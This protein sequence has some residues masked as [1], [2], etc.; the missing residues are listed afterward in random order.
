MDLMRRVGLAVVAL[1]LAACTGPLD[2]QDH[3]EPGPGAGLS[4]DEAITEVL[5]GLGT[6][7]VVTIEP[8]ATPA[9]GN[10]N[11]PG[12]EVHVTGDPDDPAM[13]VRVSWLSSLCAGAV[14]AL[15]QTDEGVMSEVVDQVREYVDLP[16]GRSRFLGGGTGTGTWMG[17][18]P[19][20]DAASVGAQVRTAAGRFGL[21]VTE[22]EVLHPIGA[23]VM[24]TVRVPD[25]AAVDWTIDELRAAIEG[26]PRAYEGTLIE[27]DSAAGVPLLVSG[28]AWRVGAG[29][30]WFAEGQ[31]EVFGATH[32]Y[33]AVP[34]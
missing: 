28:A 27:I 2:R 6:E 3:A 34:N 29:S 7:A 1:V 20:R 33:L 15:M 18:F 31:D 19:D 12:L 30:L 5:D 22:V 13:R 24:V 10:V 25:P 9:P 32:G 17:D 4:A 21:E 11:L 8:D 26:T 14:S 16:R 23:A